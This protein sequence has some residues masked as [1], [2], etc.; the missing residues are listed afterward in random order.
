MKRNIIIIICI[1]VL[2]FVAGLCGF[3]LAQPDA[4]ENAQNDRLIGVLI[5]TEYL[6]LFD[7]ERYLND[8]IRKKDGEDITISDDSSKYQ[9]R[10]YATLKYRSLTSKDSGEVVTTKEYV[11][12]EVKG[13]SYF[14]Y[15]ITDGDETY[16]T[17]SGNEA[18]SDG[19]TNISVTD[20]GESV[21]L[22]GTI[23]VAAAS[24][25]VTY[26]MNPV[27]QSADGRVYAMNGS[28][29]SFDGDSEGV[30]GSQTMDATTTVMENGE[31]NTYSISVKTTIS[32][33][34]PPRRVSVLQ[35]DSDDAILSRDEYLPGS[36]PETIT[37]KQ[38]CSY[39]IL[40]T[41]K[42]S[43]KQGE[44]VFRTLYQREDETL[45]SFY[46]RDDGVC[47]KQSTALKWTL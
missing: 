31:K 17:A 16:N 46:L 22:D 6:D 32:V 36:L 21:T 30:A 24:G 23:Y 42:T 44:T 9:G 19:Q 8:N 27:Y 38:G 43:P 33:M 12:G 29:I 41:I 26:Y 13:F 39:I 40:E 37:P 35:F 20:E 28:G 1:L 14:Y 34:N 7:V 11:F 3:T 18:I 45:E 4:S 2:L 5:T 25:N 47:V 10:L 15:T